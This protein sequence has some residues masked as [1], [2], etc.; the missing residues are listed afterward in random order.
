MLTNGSLRLLQL[1]QYILKFLY[2]RIMNY[3][4]YGINTGMRQFSDR[5]CVI[6]VKNESLEFSNMH[7]AQ[8][9]SMHQM[10]FLGNIVFY[11]F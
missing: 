2:S 5:K 8:L 3:V 1:R 11:L 10:L 4:S 7:G 9:I 6:P